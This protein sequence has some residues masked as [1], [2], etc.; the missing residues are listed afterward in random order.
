MVESIPAV[1]VGAVLEP[2]PLGPPGPPGPPVPAAPPP[3]PVIE[4]D[5]SGIS[6]DV[7]VNDDVEFAGGEEVVEEQGLE[8]ELVIGNLVTGAE[9]CGNI[10]GNVA[11]ASSDGVENELD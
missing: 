6:E 8:V 3:T 5:V 4:G 9:V 2:A 10:C 7:V 11:M 1:D